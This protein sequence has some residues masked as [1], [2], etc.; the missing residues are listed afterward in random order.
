MKSFNQY[1]TETV[2]DKIGERVFF[3]PFWADNQWHMLSMPISE[4]MIERLFGQRK[5]RGYHITSINYVKKLAKIQNSA[6]SVSTLTSGKDHDFMAGIA[7]GGGVIVEL[8][9][10]LLFSSYKD[11]FSNLELA[12]GRRWVRVENIA[13]TFIGANKIYAEIVKEILKYIDKNKIDFFKDGVYYTD[14]N[15]YKNNLI[16]WIS[17][18]DNGNWSKEYKH[19]VNAGWELHA[20]GKPVTGKD[21]ANAIR[22]YYDTWESYIKKNSKMF[23]EMLFSGLDKGKGIGDEVEGITWNEHILNRFKI[24]QVFFVDKTQE[25]YIKELKELLPDA[26][27]KKGTYQSFK[28]EIDKRA[29]L[30][31]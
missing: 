4:K 27:F 18:F 5:F 22:F 12:Q 16:P 2:I 6:K 24:T 17:F 1:I 15:T 19:L 30:M 7:S 14:E 10:N 20:N 23:S 29:G 3:E 31:K 8:E 13:D 25:W 11:V 21:K 26:K 9:G 28:K